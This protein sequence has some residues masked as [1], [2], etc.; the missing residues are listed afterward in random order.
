M[1]GGAGGALD[2][3]GMAFA[4]FV[5]WDFFGSDFFGFEGLGMLVSTCTSGSSL[6]TGAASCAEEE[7]AE[8]IAARANEPARAKG[9]MDE[10]SRC[11]A[12]Q[13]EGNMMQCPNEI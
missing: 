9:R 3:A 11:M 1:G 8:S 10:D 13:N 12:G 7:F 2:A 5:G 6:G 4:A